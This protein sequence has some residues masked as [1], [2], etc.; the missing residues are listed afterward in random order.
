MAISNLDF[1]R[2]EKPERQ[3]LRE[4]FR[5]D[6][7]DHQLVDPETNRGSVTEISLA[8]KIHYDESTGP[9]AV[10]EVAVRDPFVEAD[11]DGYARI[12]DYISH[13]EQRMLA[14]GFNPLEERNEANSSEEW[15]E[16]TRAWLHDENVAGLALWRDNVPS[17]LALGYLAN[18]WVGEAVT[19]KKGDVSDIISPETA[20]QLRFVDDAIAIRDRAV[21][22]EEIA[23]TSIQ[24]RHNAGDAIQWLS[25][26][27]GTAEPSIQ[28]AKSAAEDQ[29]IH[30]DLTVTDYDSRALKFVAANAERLG[31]QGQTKTV[32]ANILSPDIKHKLLS[33]S[34]GTAQFDVVENMGFE[35]YL[36]QQGDELGAFKGE[37]LPQASEFTRTAWEM[38]KPGGVLISGNMI[39][40]RPQI[41]FVFGIVDWPLINARSEKSILRVYK[42][43]GILDDPSAVVEMFRIRNEQTGAHVYN[44]VRVT[45]AAE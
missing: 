18:P 32:K 14:R 4:E 22:M 12:R 21:A 10:Y 30:V 40:D 36:P 45:K 39:L 44:V 31:F 42:E 7:S 9:C 35:E 33:D 13:I 38:V 2:S 23:K 43:T 15:N 11:F 26:A 17:A 25:L 19:T 5:L 16:F 6:L 29:G 1:E 37:G 20:A 34:V 24:A 3:L 28:A 27:S 8:D 41:N